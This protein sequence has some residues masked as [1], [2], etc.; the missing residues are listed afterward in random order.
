MPTGWSQPSTLLLPLMAVMLRVHHC[1][2]PSHT[3]ATS[4]TWKLQTA[5]KTYPSSSPPARDTQDA[6]KP[7]AFGH[8][9][10]VCRF[11]YPKPLQPETTVVTEDEPTLLTARNDSMLN[12]FNPVQLSAWRANVHMQYIVS[13][14][15]VIDYCTK[16]VTKSEPRSESLKDT[17]TKIVKNLKDGNRSLKAV[18][19]L[20]IHTVGDRDYSAQETCHILL[21]LPMYKCSRDFIVLSLDG[22]RAVEDRVHDDGRVTAPS[23]LDHYLVRPATPVFNNMTLL[24]FTQ[25][26][27][28]AQGAGG[29]PQQE[30]QEGCGHHTALLLSLSSRSQVRTILP[31]VTH[32]AQELPA[33]HRPAS[34]PRD[35]RSGLC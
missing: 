31:A 33:S 18:Q 10:K 1:H 14:R 20:L 15:R 7:T 29:S 28:H 26:Y 4:P 21:Q 32:E 5:K 23:T 17:F 12:S 30:E 25:S 9:I 11:G 19:K 8:A 35:L 24:E 22:S 34:W 3:S 27:N 13:R 2:S 6:L 16:Y